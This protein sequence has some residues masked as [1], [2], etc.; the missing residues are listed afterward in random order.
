MRESIIGGKFLGNRVNGTAFGIV[1]K[2]I[3]SLIYY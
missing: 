2:E 3:K 1:D